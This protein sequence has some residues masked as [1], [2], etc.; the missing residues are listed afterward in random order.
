[1]IGTPNNGITGNIVSLCSFFGATAECNDL[2]FGSLFLNKLN[3]DPSPYIKTYN[4]IGTGCDMSGEQGDGI[5]LNRNAILP[6]AEEYYING[7][8]AGLNL[9]HVDVL[10]TNK[11]PE[12]YKI[13]KEILNDTS[14]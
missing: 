14:K 2:T 13:L 7:T 5:V 1:M 8:C 10:N 12:L 3:N 11:Y 9:L 4:I 6:N